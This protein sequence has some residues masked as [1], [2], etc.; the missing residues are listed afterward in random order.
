MLACLNI[1]IASAIPC[2]YCLCIGRTFVKKYQNL[3]FPILFS[4]KNEFF[5]NIYIDRIDVVAIAYF[6]GSIDKSVIFFIIVSYT[7]Y[8]FT[9][10]GR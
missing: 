8:S 9:I 6:A 2:P 1:N 10:S 7:F 5:T 4:E 3:Y